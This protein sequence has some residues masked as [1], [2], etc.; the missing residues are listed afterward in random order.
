PVRTG[1]A[2]RR[3]RRRVLPLTPRRGYAKTRN[4][5]AQG[6]QDSLVQTRYDETMKTVHGIDSHTGGEPTRL[7]LSGCP[8]L[9]AGPLSERL[10]RFE[11]GHDFLRT[12]IINEPRGSDIVVGALLC[13]PDDA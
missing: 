3:P 11:S 9:G 2:R 4:I 7:V 6:H 8:D 12:G 1:T 5:H 13:E 10:R